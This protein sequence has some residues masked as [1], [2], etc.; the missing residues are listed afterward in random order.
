MSSSKSNSANNI[1]MSKED[2][3]AAFSKVQNDDNIPPATRNLLAKIQ[4]QLSQSKDFSQ[5]AKVVNGVDVSSLP[6]YQQPASSQGNFSATMQAL[7]ALTGG[8]RYSNSTTTAGATSV[9]PTS[10]STGMGVDPEYVSV[11]DLNNQLGDDDVFNYNNDEPTNYQSVKCPQAY[12]VHPSRNLLAFIC[13]CNVVLGFLYLHWRYNSSLK[14]LENSWFAWTFLLGETLVMI[15]AWQSHCSR[16]FPVKRE[17]CVMDE[18][19]RVDKNLGRK[20]ATAVFMPTAGEKLDVL[21]Q[22]LMSNFAMKLWRTEM[23]TRDLMRVVVLDEK[24]RPEVILLIALIYQLAGIFTNDMNIRMQ[25]KRDRVPELN[26]RGLYDFYIQCTAQYGRRY[27]A[28][29]NEVFQV[30][31]RIDLLCQ[32]NKIPENN[33]DWD[34]GMELPCGR[35]VEPT[36][37]VNNGKLPRLREDFDSIP[38]IIRVIYFSRRNPGEPWISPKS[39]NMN[40]VLFPEDP[41]DAGILGPAAFI[42]I[43]DARH[44]FEPDYVRRVQPYFWKLEKTTNGVFRYNL[45]KNVAFC[46]VPQRFRDRGDGDPFGNQSA[47][48]FDVTNVGRD[49]IG[50]VMSCGQGSMW[51]MDVVRDGIN[52]DGS[53]GVDPLEVRS[54][55]GKKIGFSQESRI[56]DTLTSINL[57]RRGFR[58]IYINKQDEVLGRCTQEPDSMDWRIKQ[59]FR[60]H[61]GAVELFQMG[62]IQMQQGRFPSIWH[63]VYTWEAC[64]YFFQAAA[65][66]VFLL[67][68]VYYCFTWAPPFNTHKTDFVIF[69]VPYFITATIPTIIGLGWRKVNPDLALR[70]EQV[71]MATSYVQLYALMQAIW[72]KIVS[73]TIAINKDTN[74]SGQGSNWS[75]DC[76]TWPLYAMFFLQ[77]AAMITSSVR[78][79][80]NDFE[81][82]WVWMSSMGASML[83]TYMLWPVVVSGLKLPPLSKFY[84]RYTVLGLFIIVVAA[85]QK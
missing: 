23:E 37:A 41:I 6:K 32:N 18:L 10:N 4:S 43:N 81:E 58:S 42:V 56:E 64:T 21:R 2:L 30:C 70:E 26:V 71:W 44:A 55:I 50:G 33:A 9:N 19:V 8:L 28:I 66:Q 38:N 62:P 65:A 54:L 85:W 59:L 72:Q 40:S 73:A 75:L 5:D 52:S 74:N 47:V 82:P 25:L 11:K 13:A 15:S 45:A 27:S 12:K 76:P 53:R 77:F 35:R 31:Q 49:G 63:R 80:K 61:F 22:A 1:T 60:W 79:F 17:D 14:G 36:L 84:M 34:T 46:Q 83:A 69:L 3:M 78:W 57:F 20:T 68:P 67:M 7:N 48:G 51:R 39:G 24:R 29:Y 16:F